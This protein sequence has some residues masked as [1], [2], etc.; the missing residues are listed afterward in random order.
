M[1][2]VTIDYVKNVVRHLQAAKLVMNHQRHR[3]HEVVGAVSER[4]LS[5]GRI[6]AAAEL[7]EAVDDVQGMNLHAHS[8]ALNTDLVSPQEALALPGNAWYDSKRHNID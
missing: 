1:C 8:Q 5:I 7:H 6:Q 4:L 2:L 3:M